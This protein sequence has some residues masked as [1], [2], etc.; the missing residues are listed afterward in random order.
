MHDDIPEGHQQSFRIS[1]SPMFNLTQIGVAGKKKSCWPFRLNSRMTIYAKVRYLPFHSQTL[2]TK[3]SSRSHQVK[4]W[5]LRYILYRSSQS[6]RKTDGRLTCASDMAPVER[7]AYVQ[8]TVYIV[9][10]SIHDIRWQKDCVWLDIFSLLLVRK[11]MITILSCQCPFCNEFISLIWN[12][13]LGQKVEEREGWST[14]KNSIDAM[15]VKLPFYPRA[16]GATDRNFCLP[17]SLKCQCFQAT[18][19][20]ALDAP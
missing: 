4:L 19:R 6:T 15:R 5:V 20:Q 18:P 16:S 3:H 8:V 12:H 7:S 9:L 11:S 10:C 2:P 13:G 17:A 14:G 1:R